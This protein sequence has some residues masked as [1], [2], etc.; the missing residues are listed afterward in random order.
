[1]LVSPEQIHR[2][3]GDMLDP[4]RGLHTALLIMPNGRLICSAS[5]FG[6]PGDAEQTTSEELEEGQ[7][8]VEGQWLDRPERVRLL[9]GLASQW[10]EDESPRIECEVSDR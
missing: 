8:V 2:Y 5:V 10:A 1:M 4:D 3:L 7:E 6:A 9:L